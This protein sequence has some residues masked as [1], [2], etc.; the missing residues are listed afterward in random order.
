MI[1]CYSFSTKVDMIFRYA[2]D[3]KTV[4]GFWIT[5]FLAIDRLKFK[6][7]SGYFSYFYRLL[8]VF[9]PSISLIALITDNISP[10]IMLGRLLKLRL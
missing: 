10:V 7:V 6:V 5:F 8:I 2:Q 1:F 9:S 3:D 4:G